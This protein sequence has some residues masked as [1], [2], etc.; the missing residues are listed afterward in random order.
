M[1]LRPSD[2]WVFF[3]EKAENMNKN[4][5]INGN[6]LNEIKAIPSDSINLIFA[7]SPYYM[8]TTGK[9]FRP[10][11]TVFQGYN[12]DWDKFETLEEYKEFTFEWLN[13]C[14]CIL[15]PN[16]S[17]WIIGGMQCIYTIGYMI[18]EVGF[19]LINNIVWHKNNLTANFMGI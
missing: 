7:D 2:T 6:Y 11:G 19:Y 9:L 13:D 4:I 18:Q 16:G 8:R 3:R 1:T 12:D 5:I 15:K 10:D 17:M 14:Y